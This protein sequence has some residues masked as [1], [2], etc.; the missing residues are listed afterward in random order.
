[1]PSSGASSISAR[2]T[3]PHSLSDSHH[4]AAAT[5]YEVAARASYSGNPFAARQIVLSRPIISPRCSPVCNV[6]NFS[7]RWRIVFGGRSALRMAQGPQRRSL[8]ESGE[9]RLCGWLACG[10]FQTLLA[11]MIL[12]AGQQKGHPS[13]WRGCHSVGVAAAGWL[14]SESECRCVRR[15]EIEEAP[16]DGKGRPLALPMFCQ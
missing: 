6:K 14:E 4:P 2:R 12:S 15:A 1:M 16:D 3:H 9:S 13:S 7:H 5:P 10:E 8:A 11:L